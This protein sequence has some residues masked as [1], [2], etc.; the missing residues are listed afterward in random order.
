MLRW[1]V[2]NWTDWGD[3]VE[4]LYT[5]ER[6]GLVTL[7]FHYGYLILCALDRSR[8]FA[9]VKAEKAMMSMVLG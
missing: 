3:E 2:G 9:C 4:A 8:C 7:S 5:P 6:L 1:L